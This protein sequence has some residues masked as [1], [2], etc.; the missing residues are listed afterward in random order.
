M[1]RTP[2]ASRAST[3]SLIRIAP[4]WAVKPAPTVADRASPATRG[5]ISRGVEVGG[6]EPGEG[7]GA[8]LVEG[9]VPLESDDRAGEQGHRDHHA[10]GAADDAESATAEGDL[11][12]QP[13]HLAQMA[14]ARV[15]GIQASA[16][17]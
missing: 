5:A 12:Q 1:D 7:R 8:D 6:D 14:G 15:R 13:L 3:S 17:T 9:G 11:G 4:S 16:L 2:M 10:D